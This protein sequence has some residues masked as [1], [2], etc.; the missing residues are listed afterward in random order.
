MTEQNHRTRVLRVSPTDPA[1][2]ALAQAAD[3]LRAGGLVAFP[4]ETVYGLGANALD[5]AAVQRIFT[6]KQRPAT[7]PIIVHLVTADQL[8][9]VAADIPPL[10]YDLAA[11]FWPGAL[12]LILPKQHHI[13][14]VV[15]AGSATV[16]V[17]VPAHPVAS[18]LLRAADLPI[19]A[20]SANTFS[21]PSPTRAEHVL[22]DLDGHFDLLLDGGETTIGVESTILSLVEHPPR[23]L[24]PGGVSL[25]ALRRVIPQIDYAPRYLAVDQHAPAPGTLIKHYSPLA[26]V[27]LY[28][29]EKTQVL[30]SVMAA[31]AT[32]LDN[33]AK[34]GLLLPDADLA[35]LHGQIPAAV[36]SI[37]LGATLEAAAGNLFAALRDMDR[38]GVTLIFTRLLEGD[39][40]ALAINDRLTRAAENHIH[41]V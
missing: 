5:A 14:A 32:E 37:S 33:G 40:L 30:A 21:R 4:T 12:T 31:L 27:R 18:A 36:L 22:A 28:S 15:T 6:A 34:V 3:V 25:E 29:G 39:G 16:A 24:R 2:D 8:P 13:P 26:Q 1:A 17:R 10:A 20:P 38:S 35:A 7:D 41:E 23:L 11:L 9:T 19:A